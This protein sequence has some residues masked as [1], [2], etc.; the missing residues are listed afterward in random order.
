MLRACRYVSVVII[1][2]SWLV[3]LRAALRVLRKYAVLTRW[4]SPHRHDVESDGR[5]LKDASL[6]VVD[7]VER[8]IE[9]MLRR[10]VEHSLFARKRF[11]FAQHRQERTQT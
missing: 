6:Q 3:K 9:Q 11:F 10:R 8:R 2:L 1:H 4:L 7:V 5:T